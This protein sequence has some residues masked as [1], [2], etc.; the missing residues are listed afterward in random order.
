MARHSKWHNIQ[1]KKGATDAKRAV[2]F[3]KL[4]KAITVA[5]RE[6]GGDPS[7]NFSLRVAIDN[8]KSANMPKDKIEKAIERGTKTGEA[9][10]LEEVIY[11]GYAPGGIGML[12]KCLTDNRNRTVADVKTIVSKN[13]GSIGGAGSV[14]WMFERKGVVVVEDTAQI[15]DSDAFELALIDAGAQDI[16]EDDGALQIVSEVHDLQSVLETV[17]GMGLKVKG[18]GIEYL[19]KETVEIKDDT[20]RQQV[21]TLL[22]ALDENNDVDM[23]Y[24]NALEL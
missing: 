10:Q 5:A 18:A 15:K 7:F 4:A 20:I 24:T 12:I 19:P 3:T 23:V 13:G 14:M 17:E 8:A 2:L 22:E 1:K 16:R 6:G 11:E 9:D 21:E